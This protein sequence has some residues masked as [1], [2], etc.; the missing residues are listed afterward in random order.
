MI[1]REPL[2]HL[3]PDV[4]LLGDC[5]VI[6]GQI[7]R[8]LASQGGRWEEDACPGQELRQETELIGKKPVDQPLE[9]ATTKETVEESAAASTVQSSSSSSEPAAAA[10]ASSEPEKTEE[11]PSQGDDSE[12]KLDTTADSNASSQASWWEPRTKVMKSSHK[13]ITKK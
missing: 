5:D 8:M 2:P 13:P 3:T 6:V 4:E 9:P 10:A 7:C 12:D 1:N 11:V